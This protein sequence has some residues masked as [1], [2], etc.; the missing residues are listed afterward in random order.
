MRRSLPTIPVLVLLAI[1]A[2]CA[3][4]TTIPAA[5][6]LSQP[7]TPVSAYI[8]A[9]EGWNPWTAA[10]G[11]GALSNTPTPMA[12]Y[13]QA[14][15]GELWAPCVPGGGG[16][17]ATLPYPGLV[18][19]TSATGGTVATS[20]EVITAF[21]NPSTT[22][23]INSASTY[24]GTP[25]GTEYRPFLTV[26]DAFNSM[27][28]NTQYTAIFAGGGE[29]SE[30][31]FTWP[32]APTAVTVIGNQSVYV[33]TS[34]TVTAT[35]PVVMFEMYLSGGEFDFA[36][37]TLPSR[38]WGG[39]ILGSTTVT[40]NVVFHGT[41]FAPVFGSATV[42]VGANSTAVFDGSLM[43]DEII[44][45]GTGAI[46]T[47]K[48]HTE[49]S[50]TAD[51][52]PNIDMS[53]GGR[54]NL[55]ESQLVNTGTGFNVNCDD[56]ATEAA[57]N[58]ITA[59][60]SGNN[61]I[62]CGTAWANLSLATEFPS[63][64]GS[65]NIHPTSNFQLGTGGTIAV[66]GCALTAAA[67]GSAAGQFHSGTTGTCT[68]TVTSGYIAPN[69]WFVRANDL[70]TPA[71]TLNQTGSTTTTATFSGTTVTGDLINFAAVPY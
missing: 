30:A 46:V 58:L 42:T 11:Y 64:Y 10:A 24:G 52:V 38:L 54:L 21:T 17:G 34:G 8:N 5:A 35:V 25:D 1:L 41:Q 6:Q 27:T 39:A 33:V 63:L 50:N 56:G 49:M 71:D 9:G 68:V 19:A 15:P 61:G 37:G 36:T 3:A 65:T 40:G 12:L 28:Q 66:S 18:Y 31:A 45:A 60:T 51:G 67:G 57:P 55:F 62:S 20:D 53:A 48:G 69:G 70:T 2:L 59:G 29:Y 44:S 47:I 26:A 23:Y 13:C 4:L 16:G 22:V 7:P 32:T 14:A 43:S